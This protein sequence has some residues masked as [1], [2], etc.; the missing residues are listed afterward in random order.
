MDTPGHSDPPPDC[1]TNSFASSGFDNK[2]V[3]RL[4]IRKVNTDI[5]QTS[6]LRTEPHIRTYRRIGFPN[7]A[8][9]L[10]PLVSHLIPGA[11]DRTGLRWRESITVVPL[12]LNT[13][14]YRVCQGKDTGSP[15]GEHARN[16]TQRWVKY[17]QTQQL[18]CF[19]PDCPGGW[20]KH[21]T[22]LLVENNPIAGFVH[23]L[24]SIV[25]CTVE[26]HTHGITV[27]ITAYKH[28]A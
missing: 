11:E 4:F 24:P 9:L 17:E 16:T 19:D 22:Q 13:G 26:E 5:E 10:L 2:V 25:L 20:V 15:R 18:G 7:K 6:R 12:R 3:R 8:P 23:I 21:L 14:R 28:L 1:E 27:G